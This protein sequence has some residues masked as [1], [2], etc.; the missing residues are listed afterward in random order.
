MLRAFQT[1]WRPSSVKRQYPSSEI[2]QWLCPTTKKATSLSHVKSTIQTLKME[3][4]SCR[5]VWLCILNYHLT[6]TIRKEMWRTE[7]IINAAPSA[8]F[9]S[10]YSLVRPENF[11]KQFLLQRQ[12]PPVC[13]C[14]FIWIL[15]LSPLEVQPPPIL[16]PPGA[17][18]SSYISLLVNNPNCLLE[19]STCTPSHLTKCNAPKIKFIN[20]S[21][22]AG[23][24]PGSPISVNWC[25][26][27]R[28]PGLH[29][30]RP[31]CALTLPCRPHLFPQP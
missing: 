25:H 13:W 16:C 7:E 17:V 31:V 12:W 27:L 26:S 14:R 1:A 9:P 28:N 2:P 24:F 5:F 10:D 20:L 15:R 6:S 11:I 18:I 3:M 23:S 21:P 8:K 30:P 29:P 22:K 4:S 19:I